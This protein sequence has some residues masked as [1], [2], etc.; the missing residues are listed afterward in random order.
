MNF[1]AKKFGGLKYIYYLC[2]VNLNPNKP[3]LKA[4]QKQQRKHENKFTLNIYTGSNIERVF[5]PDAAARIYSSPGRKL[6]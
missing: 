6:R 4:K 5:W 2:T 1:I 3:T